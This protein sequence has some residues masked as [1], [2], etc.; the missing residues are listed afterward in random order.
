MHENDQEHEHPFYGTDIIRN[1]E[2]EYIQNILKKYR[3]DPVNE[4]LQHKIWDE[5]QMEKYKGNIKIPFKVVMRRDIYKKFPD[6]IE[7]ILDTKV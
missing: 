4:E 6:Y 5:L 7:I 2:K 1:R 3:H